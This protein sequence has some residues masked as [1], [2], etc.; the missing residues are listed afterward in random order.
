MP[1]IWT[2][3][4]WARWT[5]LTEV[6]THLMWRVRLLQIQ[7]WRKSPRLSSRNLYQDPVYEV[8][9]VLQRRDGGICT[10][11]V[12]PIFSHFQVPNIHELFLQCGNWRRLRWRGYWC[13]HA[14][15]FDVNPFAPILSFFLIFIGS[16]KRRS[17]W[18]TNLSLINSINA[19]M[20]ILIVPRFVL[21]TSMSCGNI[22][23]HSKEILVVYAIA[24]I[25]R[26][27]NSTVRNREFYYW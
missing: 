23:A 18:Q 2:S 27:V 8:I 14:F 21:P 4:W 22:L 1:R 26:L 9:I 10:K 7:I 11:L 20:I 6:M 24:F 13:L 3:G 19:H 12:F 15:I 5:P 16:N 25:V 17:K